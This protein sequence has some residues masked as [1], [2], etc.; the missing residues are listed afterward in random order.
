MYIGI[1]N[2]LWKNM[3]YTLFLL[4]CFEKMINK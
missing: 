4:G 1:Q 3:L 2:K